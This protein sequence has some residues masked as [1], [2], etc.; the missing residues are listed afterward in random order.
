MTQRRQIGR[1]KG[2]QNFSRTLQDMQACHS[3]WA[4]RFYTAFVFSIGVVFLEGNFWNIRPQEPRTRDPIWNPID[5]HKTPQPSRSVGYE[6]THVQTPHKM[7]S[8]F[9]E[10]RNAY[11]AHST[12]RRRALRAPSGGAERGARKM[13]REIITLNVGQCGVQ[14]GSEFFKR[15]CAEH[16]L[17]P[18]G[19]LRDIATD[20]SLRGAPFIRAIPSA[21]RFSVLLPSPL[22]TGAG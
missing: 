15:L 3:G 10:P 9:P 16:G 6:Q 12:E 1:R 11:P 4:G 13:P 2:A 7:P 17:S 18:D 20:V 21:L 8:L 5:H 19:T 14:I 22:Q